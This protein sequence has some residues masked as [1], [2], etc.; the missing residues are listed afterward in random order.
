MQPHTQYMLS[1]VSKLDIFTWTLTLW[2][3]FLG[4]KVLLGR[5][6]GSPSNIKLM[7]A[8]RKQIYT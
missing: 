4:T 1:T 2:K 3:H 8:P 6:D 5:G 7:A